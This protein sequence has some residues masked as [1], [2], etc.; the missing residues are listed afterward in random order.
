MVDC[1]HACGIM[2]GMACGSIRAPRFEAYMFYEPVCMHACM[3][4][5]MLLLLLLCTCVDMDWH[6]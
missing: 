5:C 6:T 4:A 2:C 3:H 1:E